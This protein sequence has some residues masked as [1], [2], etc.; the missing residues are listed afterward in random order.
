MEA[1]VD[2]PC[3][4][5]ERS[6]ASRNARLARRLAEKSR[7]L[8]RVAHYAQVAV[9][10]AGI[11]VMD[12]PASLRSSSPGEA[13]REA[14]SNALA[15]IIKAHVLRSFQGR[16]RRA[17]PPSLDLLQNRYSIDLLLEIPCDVWLSAWD[18]IR[19]R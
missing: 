9:S 3:S 8:P 15:V 19:T 18:S 2:S 11:A 12:G 1:G 16:L 4:A 6:V 7:D 13:T 5:D 14:L 10:W 17:T